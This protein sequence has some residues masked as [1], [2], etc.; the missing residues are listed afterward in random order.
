LQFK[1]VKITSQIL[2]E[3][4]DQFAAAEN[5]TVVR[6]NSPPGLAQYLPETASGFLKRFCKEYFDLA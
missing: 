2:L 1:D 6:P 3:N 4:T 5:C